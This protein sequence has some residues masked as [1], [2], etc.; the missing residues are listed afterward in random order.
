M[1][2]NDTTDAW[3]SV[4][5]VLEEPASGAFEPSEILTRLR[6]VTPGRRTVLRSAVGLGGALGLAALGWLPPM[7]QRA[8]SANVGTE[9]MSCKPSSYD[10][11]CTGAPYSKDWC[12]ADGWFKNYH[13]SVISMGPIKAC[14]SRNAWRW[15]SGGKTYRCADGQVQPR[16]GSAQLKICSWKL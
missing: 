3:V 9:H 10:G 1:T 6:D 5:S 8:A 13:D 7:R 2:I 4:P 16:G 11:I 15:P 14:S 12:G